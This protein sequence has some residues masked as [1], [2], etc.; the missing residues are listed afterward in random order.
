MTQH[1]VTYTPFPPTDACAVLSPLECFGFSL[2]FSTSIAQ[3][4]VCEQPPPG[5]AEKWRPLPLQLGDL[6]PRPAGH[7]WWRQGNAPVTFTAEKHTTK[8]STVPIFKQKKTLKMVPLF[9]SSLCVWAAAPGGWRLSSSTLRLS[10]IWRTPNQSIPISVRGLT[11]MLC[12]KSAPCCLSA[13]VAQFHT[14]H[15]SARIQCVKVVFCFAAWDGHP[16]YRHHVA[17]A[18]KAPPSCTLQRCDHYT[19]RDV[20]WHRWVNKDGLASLSLCS[21]QA[22]HHFRPWYMCSVR[23]LRTNQIPGLHLSV[24]ECVLMSLECDLMSCWGCF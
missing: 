15:S 9:F 18:D 11:A 22:T 14:A 24:S 21:T 20:W 17:R 8:K 6:H 23:Q 4:S 19:Y 12:I 3:P 7:V 2:I 1:E 10:S 13:Y 16:V 5:S